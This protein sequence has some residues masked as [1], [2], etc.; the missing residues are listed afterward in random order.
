MRR[1]ALLVLAALLPACHSTTQIV[2]G[3]LTN[4]AVPSQLTAVRLEASRNGVQVEQRLW[5][6]SGQKGVDFTLPG[7][8][9]LYSTRGG[10]PEV[11]LELAG[12]VGE[13][14]VLTRHSQIQLVADEQPFYRMTL[15]QSCEGVTCPAGSGCVEGVCRPDTVDPRV[16]PPYDSAL[17]LT[18]QCDSGSGFI[19]T[20]TCSTGTC[21][22][23]PITGPACAIDE[24]CREGA[25]DKKRLA[26]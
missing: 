21:A 9:D 26:P 5:T 1:L 24:V 13:T 7:T 2:V 23:L 18:V 25:C 4:L 11:E 16:L 22:P 8:Y 15:V 19:D 14:Q 20:S 17:A 3:I 10:M 6:L 12:F